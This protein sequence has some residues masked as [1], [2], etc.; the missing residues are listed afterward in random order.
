MNEKA[1]M[2][3]SKKRS[4]TLAVL[5]ILLIVLFFSSIFIGSSNISF[6]DGL[7]GLFGIGDET[8]II[9]VQNIRLPRIV[10]AV[11]VGIALSLSGVIMQTMSNNVMASPTT[12]GVSNAAVLGA[13][14]AIIIIGGGVIAFNGGNITITNPYF[15]SGIAFL[16]ALLGI[17]LVL[18]LSRINKF[19]NAT[20]V[21]VGITFGTFCTG[22]TTLIQY[23]ASDT[24]LATAVYWSFGDLGRANYV[25]DLIILVVAVIS[26]VFFLIFSYRYNAMLLGEDTSSTLGINLNVFRFISLLLASLLTAVCV[27]LVGIIGFIGLIVPQVCRKLVGNDHR[28]L[29]IT[30]SLMGAVVLL[31]SDIISRILLSGFSLP[32]GAI[33]SILGAPIFIVILLVGR[34]KHA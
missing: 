26:L 16:F 31:F 25:D 8:N 6:V 13:N 14:I 4:I 10:A 33:T 1:I 22:L 5:V 30:S 17:L 3:L 34:K 29:L 24:T 23:F 28:Y 2:S 18:G 19:N 12:L 11:L 21:L 15:T 7:K 32:V 9:I 20:T 27:S